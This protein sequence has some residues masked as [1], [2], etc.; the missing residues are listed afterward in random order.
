MDEIFGI[1][2]SGIMIVLLGM[3]AFCLLTVAWVAWRRPVIFK[4]GVRNIPRRKAQTVLIV[5]GLMLS[6]MIISAALGVGDTVD[7]S[8]TDE[9]YQGLG[10]VDEQVVASRDVEAQGGALGNVTMDEAAL[11]TVEQ[12]LA[13]DKNVDGIMPVLRVEAP[14]VVE[15]KGQSEPGIMLVGL[16]PSRVEQFGGLK[17]TAGKTIDLAAI[18]AE[19]VVLSAKA[20]ENLNAAVGDTITIYHDNQPIDR[21]VAAIGEDTS[22]TG[23]GRS[24]N[25]GKEQAGLA[26]PLA[27][28]QAMT[29]NENRISAVVIS[30][31]GGVR[32]S[33]DAT[34]AVVE[35]LKAAL[36]GKNLG[37]SAVKQDGLDSAK[38]FSSI[39]TGLFL[40]L[41]LFSI[42][43]GV[44]L[45]VLIFTM[46]AAERRSE[47][48]MARAVGAHRRQLIQQFIAE[49]SGYAILAGLVGSAL[50]VMAALGI[51]LGMGWLFGDF[52]DITPHVTPRS[53]IVAYC[54]GVVITFL[55]V[56]GSSWKI[57]RLNVVAAVRDLPDATTSRRKK[58]TLVWAALLL[59]GGAL[60]TMTGTN[61]DSLLAFTMGMSLL[62]FGVALILRFFG[63]PSR[64][65]FTIVG[66]YLLGFWLLP[67][68]QF[69]QIFGDYDG[70]IEMFFVSGIFMVIA[71]TIVIMQNTDLLL[72]G[73]SKLGGLFKSKL[74]AVRTAVA[75]PGAARGRT[76]MAIA[77]FS[78]IIFSLVMMATMNQNY[79]NLFLGDEAN[80]GWD[81][82]ADAYN[83]NPVGDFR[84]AL[85][86]KGVD[87][88][89]FEQVGVVTSPTSFTAPVRMAGT[90]D[91]KNF[92]VRGMNDDFIA[93]ST[94]T[95]G[96]RAQ[97]Y[98][99]DADV[100]KALEND[101]NLAVVDVSAVPGNGGF[102]GFDDAF[103]LTGLK[104][105]DKVFKPIAVELA[106]PQGGEA[107]QVTV[108]GVIDTK[109][110]SLIGLY[111][112]QQ[113][114]DTVYPTTT[115]TSY[116]VALKDKGQS[117]AVAK[118]VEAALLQNGVQATSIRDELKENQKQSTGFLYIIQGFMGLGLLVGV[119]AIG[120]IAFR[121]VVER[122]Q[123][124][125][126]LRAIGYQRGMVS[127]SFMIETAFV[128]GMGCLTGTALGLVLARN[129]FTSDATAADAGFLI[130][131]GIISTV[132]AITILVALLMT[133]IPSRQAARIAPAEAL[134]YE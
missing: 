55:A 12:A 13:D 130:P 112:N 113:T 80:A 125:G 115:M 73:V 63:V 32:D 69:A 70:G 97:G 60:L 19:G 9:V 62:P 105:S 1:P 102:G 74:P 71:A 58:R 96:Q 47:M 123:Q 36:A 53:M 29:G 120:V 42:A 134:R 6:T 86:A 83:V 88:S 87:T 66:L 52:V 11:G 72:A 25:T 49:G 2:M 100:V 45:I 128:V 44:L 37:V 114:I 39:F 132:L 89:G 131:W 121:S 79:V 104:A 4:L 3:L 116:Y 54:L 129:L 59:I 117:D 56:T 103:T 17:D 75:Y 106:D 127:L 15:A 31:T 57:S 34:D 28:L 41:G 26:M 118:E 67:E 91:W 5:V 126:V 77:M 84:G 93:D 65:V 20:A 21:T 124:I 22:L 46:L 24:E 111:A 85:A 7:Y 18:P 30:N 109:I 27:N 94:L 14:V 40:V 133:W 33:L 98:A 82:R 16:D 108:I 50:G 61:S 78:L 119:A 51:G 101:P 95:F 68:K 38:T 122:R 8:I 90:Q 76:G 64:P 48:G 110:G 23:V 43:A 92:P 10:H 81:V 107:H 99:T 35:K